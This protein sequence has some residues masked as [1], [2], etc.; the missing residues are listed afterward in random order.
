[1]SPEYRRPDDLWS[2]D[3]EILP[4]VG[5]YEPGY[6]PRP[7]GRNLSPAI[8]YL[9]IGLAALLVI[10]LATGGFF[11]ARQFG[12]STDTPNA[13]PTT[14]P[15]AAPVTTTSAKPAPSA[16]PAAGASLAVV[17]GWINEGTPTGATDFHTATTTGGTKNDLGSAVAFASPSKKIQCMTPKAGNSFGQGGLTCMVEFDDPPARPATR[18]SGQW[19]GSW[20]DFPG[21]TLGIG[22]LEGDPGQFSLGDGATLAYGS[23]LSIDDYDCRM[24]QTGLFCANRSTGSAVQLSSAGAVAFGCLG[25]T[26]ARE[27]GIEYSCTTTSTTTT[28]TS[29]SK[30]KSA[31]APGDKCDTPGEKAKSAGGVKLTCATAGDSGLRWLVR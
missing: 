19:V 3:T 12:S 9:L 29:T 20:V 13:L 25:K 16:P 2:Q 4:V 14:T 5:D 8:R 1:M 26:T 24:D 15:A 30:S 6:A 11:A 17:L 31:P 27:Y 28:P 18:P 21:A 10:A 23:K 22:H 7:G